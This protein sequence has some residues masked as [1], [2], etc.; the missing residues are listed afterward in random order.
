MSL[1]AKLEAEV[2]E[3]IIALVP[4]AEMLRFAKNGTDATSAAVRLSRAYTGRERVAVCGYHGWQDWF[5]GSTNRSKGVP[6]S[7]QEL[8]HLFNFND[9]NSLQSLFDVYPGEIACVIIEPMNREYPTPGYLESLIALCELNGAICVFD[10]TITGF[11]FSRGGAQEL[12][13]VRPHLSTFGKGIA[14]GYPLSVVCGRRDIM[15]EMEQI[16]FSGTFGGELLSL[17]AANYV[18]DRHLEDSVC[19]RLKESGLLLRSK[20]EEVIKNVGLEDVLSFSGHPS[21]VFYEWSGWGDYTASEI[22]ALF[23]QE[24]YAS[25]VLIIG[26]NNISLSF[27]PRVNSRVA[28]AFEKAMISLERSLRNQ[29]LPADLR[30]KPPEPVLRIR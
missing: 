4:S 25:G 3:K 28:A 7:T 27:S 11:R 23:L 24:L 6:K 1:P 17:A 9:L 30:G 13:G 8:T 26:T 21:W 15:M 14:N 10:E 5:I 12:F 19:G 2:A 20:Q 18:L 16:F 29:T 22:R